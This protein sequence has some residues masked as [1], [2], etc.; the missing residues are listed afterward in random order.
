MIE[1]A[2]ASEDGVPVS[3][4]NKTYRILCLI[5]HSLSPSGGGGHNPRASHTSSEVSL[6]GV[7]LGKSLIE[8]ASASEDGVPVSAVVKFIKWAYNY[9]QWEIYEQL[10]Q[11]LSAYIK[12][13][14]NEWMEKLFVGRGK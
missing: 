7:V 9:E 12:V 5:A 8:I 6:D 10:V 4:R 1:I 3:A 14:L 11:M 2:S 13:R